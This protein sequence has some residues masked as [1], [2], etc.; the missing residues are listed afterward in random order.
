MSI[1]PYY[2]NKHYILVSLELIEAGVSLSALISKAFISGN[3]FGRLE[4]VENYIRIKEEE[5]QGATAGFCIVKVEIS[6]GGY[7]DNNIFERYE[8]T[9][10]QRLYK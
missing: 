2:E 4:L 5:S 8:G 7:G 3:S 6:A 10:V 1:R 9:I